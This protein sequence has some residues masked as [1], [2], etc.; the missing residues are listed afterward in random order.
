[1]SGAVIAHL[2]QQLSLP[3]VVEDAFRGDEVIAVEPA[4]WHAVAQ[5]LRDD[6]QCDFKHFTDLTAVDHPERA[7]ETP[8]FDVLLLLRS[9]THG[10]RIRLRTQ[11]AEGEELDSLCDVWA[12]A[13]WAE[14]EVFDMFGITFRGHPDP[15]R[16]LMYDEFVGH[17][18]RKDY[19]IDRA[20]PLVPY[21]NVAGIDKL[22]PFA[23][24]EGQPWGRIDWS[25]RLDGG[26]LQVS[27][28]IAMH[29]GQR[30]ALSASTAQPL[31]VADAVVEQA[32]DGDAAPA[33]KG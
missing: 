22:P 3:F 6:P 11:V 30:P 26:D 16:I 25:E 5:F 29:S 7:P 21:R 14:R 19:P 28:A 12:G 23:L 32:A 1:M 33:H 17:P 31:P 9:M 10:H 2:Q 8:R 15:R 18:L 13:N 20:Q 24:E 4:H 27:P